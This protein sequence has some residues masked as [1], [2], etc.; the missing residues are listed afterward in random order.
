MGWSGAMG[1][2]EPDIQKLL[3]LVAD[4]IVERDKL[5]HKARDLFDVGQAKEANRA[6]AKAEEIERGIKEI[7]ESMRRERP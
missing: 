3:K 1:R 4:A 6:L 7:E 2:G 5:V